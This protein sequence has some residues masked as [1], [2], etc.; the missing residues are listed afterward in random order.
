MAEK[1]TKLLVDVPFF[2]RKGKNKYEKIYV[3]G[4]TLK[5]A[6]EKKYSFVLHS[7]TVY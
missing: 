7:Q 3:E 5:R 6:K 4:F 2:Y 1:V